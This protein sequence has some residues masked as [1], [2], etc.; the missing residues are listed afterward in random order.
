MK[1]LYDNA[2]SI[3]GIYI[4]PKLIIANGCAYVPPPLTEKEK[5]NIRISNYYKKIIRKLDDKPTT[6]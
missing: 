3:K 5:E 1:K 4:D 2:V 6:E